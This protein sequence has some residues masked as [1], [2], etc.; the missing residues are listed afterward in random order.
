MRSIVATVFAVW[1]SLICCHGEDPQ[2]L[3]NRAKDV[4]LGEFA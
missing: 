1:S 3:A 4:P 2:S